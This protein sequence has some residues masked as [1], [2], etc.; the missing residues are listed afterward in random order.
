ME[1]REYFIPFLQ[2]QT[3][4]T[5]HIQNTT[6]DE[7]DRSGRDDNTQNGNNNRRR[8]PRFLSTVP[9]LSSWS[10]FHIY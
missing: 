7:N 9:S 10:V 6:D 4:I 1:I 3:L 2:K 5:Q 8:R